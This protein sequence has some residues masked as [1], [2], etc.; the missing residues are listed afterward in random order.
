MPDLA[1]DDLA[2]ATVLAALSHQMYSCQSWR[3]RVSQL[4]PEQCEE[5][6]LRTIRGFRLRPSS[7]GACHLFIPFALPRFD[8]FEGAQE[9]ILE[10][11]QFSNAGA[12]W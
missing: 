5:F 9:S 10:T 8:Q 7:I 3:Q 4:M 2:L 1:F 6:I 12:D 11:L